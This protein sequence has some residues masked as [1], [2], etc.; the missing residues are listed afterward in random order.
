MYDLHFRARFLRKF[1]MAESRISWMIS[2][3]PCEKRKLDQSDPGQ[4]SPLHSATTTSADNTLHSSEV[5]PRLSFPITPS[6]VSTKL[7]D[8]DPT[9]MCPPVARWLLSVLIRQ[10]DLSTSLLLHIIGG[11]YLRA[12]AIPNQSPKHRSGCQASCG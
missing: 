11:V 12:V 10:T 8:S 7:V 3:C 2:G 6:A 4:H 1:V 9:H 5:R